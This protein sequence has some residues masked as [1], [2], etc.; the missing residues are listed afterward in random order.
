MATL[1][2]SS[3][4]GDNDSPPSVAWWNGNQNTYE[5]VQ[6]ALTAAT[7]D[8]NTIYVDNNHD[9]TGSGITWNVSTNNS[10]KIIG[11][12]RASGELEAGAKETIENN[13]SFKIGG[14]TGTYYIY[15]IYF[16]TA[17]GYGAARYFLIGLAATYNIVFEKCTF[18]ANPSNS[19]NA[20]V[21][22]AQYNN[23]TMTQV[24]FRDCN[25]LAQNSNNNAIIVNRKNNLF[26][27]GLTIGYSGAGRPPALFKAGT[28]DTY[29]WRGNVTCVDSDLSDY[30]GS[31]LDTTLFLGGDLVLRNCKLHGDTI[32][33]NGNFPTNATAV[34]LINC[35]SANTTNIYEYYK[36]NGTIVEDETVYYKGTKF[37]DGSNISWLIVPNNNATAYNPFYTPWI[38]MWN[39]T[40]D[41]SITPKIKLLVEEF[42][43]IKDS[44]L[45]VEFEYLADATSPLGTLYSSRNENPFAAGTDLDNTFIYDKTVWETGDYMIPVE[46]ILSHTFTPKRKGLI[47]ARVGMLAA[48]GPI[49]INP[50]IEIE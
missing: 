34:T 29:G 4:D 12:N 30:S 42:D 44:Q 46:Y 36:D 45:W 24:E 33:V 37:A 6:G 7:D 22:G 49:N 16:N 23:Y 15:G 43:H 8:D 28:S 17:G 3:V 13:A 27:S 18:V 1:Y 35:S 2:V 32:T 21:L 26:I 10:I 5:S 50:K 38:S 14:A 31:L 39:N 47:R 48:V 11:V 19:E 40:V 20:L 41:S 25:I 9:F